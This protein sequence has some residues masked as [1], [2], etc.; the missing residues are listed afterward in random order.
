LKDYLDLSLSALYY[1]MKCYPEEK[2]E[3]QMRRSLGRYGLTGKQQVKS[4]Y[5]WWEFA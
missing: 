4:D 3:E 5:V 1:M 2:D